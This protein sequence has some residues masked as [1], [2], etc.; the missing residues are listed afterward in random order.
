MWEKNTCNEG[1]RA[2]VSVM[3]LFSSKFPN[4]EKQPNRNMGKMESIHNSEKNNTKTHI[5]TN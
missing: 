3:Y 1:N 4:M 2:C 5:K